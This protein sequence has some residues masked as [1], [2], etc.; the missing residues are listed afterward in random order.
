[1]TDSRKQAEP[2]AEGK[3]AAE[4]APSK[5]EPNRQNET[6][7]EVTSGDVP[8]LPPSNKKNECHPN[9]VLH[10]KHR[11]SHGNRYTSNPAFPR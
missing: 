2:N 7:D 3:A 8:E 6:E 5:A 10:W 9:T 1:M 11:W 4:S